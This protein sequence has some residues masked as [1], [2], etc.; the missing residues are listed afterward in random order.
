MLRVPGPEMY[1]VHFVAIAVSCKTNVTAVASLPV[2]VFEAVSLQPGKVARRVS[3]AAL[4]PRRDFVFALT[5]QR[6]TGT[7][8]SMPPLVRACEFGL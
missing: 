8:P 1:N 5:T 6:L 7:G 4:P 2:P 3:T